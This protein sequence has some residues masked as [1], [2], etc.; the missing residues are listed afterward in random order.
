MGQYMC[1]D[2]ND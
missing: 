2:E 1:I